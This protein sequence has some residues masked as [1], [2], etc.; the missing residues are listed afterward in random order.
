MIHNA[1][2]RPRA[3]L[4]STVDTFAESIDSFGQNTLLLILLSLLSYTTY[5]RKKFMPTD[6]WLQAELGALLKKVIHNWWYR[7]SLQKGNAV[8]V[9]LWPY[10]LRE[11][12]VQNEEVA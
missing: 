12:E 8:T 10:F 7:G 11:E 4:G 1:V 2:K 6:S 3:L 5:T 9:D